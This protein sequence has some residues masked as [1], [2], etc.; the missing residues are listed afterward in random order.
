[1]NKHAM[2]TP[3][4]L[5]LHTPVLK[6]NFKKTDFQNTQR[7]FLAQNCLQAFAL[8]HI[9]IQCPERAEWKRGNVFGGIE[10]HVHL[11]LPHQWLLCCP[12]GETNLGWQVGMQLHRKLECQGPP[13]LTLGLSSLL[14]HLFYSIW[15]MWVF[16]V[17]RNRMFGHR[18]T[19]RNTNSQRTLTIINHLI[20]VVFGWPTPPWLVCFSRQTD[21]QTAETARALLQCNK[22]GE[23]CNTAIHMPVNKINTFFFTTGI[24]KHI[25][26]LSRGFN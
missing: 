24:K 9:L 20:L 6:Q 4:K 12:K 8:K 15:S 5:K 13:V 17:P 3:H 23:S 26:V 22:G 10:K 16:P 21:R 2:K 11:M 7:T 18:N 14:G 25:A 19:D 1:M